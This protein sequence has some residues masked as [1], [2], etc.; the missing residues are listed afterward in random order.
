MS[1][2]TP[3]IIVGGIDVY[4]IVGRRLGRDLT[5]SVITSSVSITHPPDPYQACTQS[6]VEMLLNAQ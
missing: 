6:R 3:F 5:T 4:N 1:T 2:S